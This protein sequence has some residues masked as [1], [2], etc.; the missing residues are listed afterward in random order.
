MIPAAPNATTSTTATT[1]RTTGLPSSPGGPLP[2]PQL[3]RFAGF[4]PIFVRQVAAAALR[5]EPAVDDDRVG[6]HDQRCEDVVARL[7]VERPGAHED[8]VLC[9]PRA[10]DA[11]APIDR[12]LG[13]RA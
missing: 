9:V 7:V 2:L 5:R 3:R 10:V 4:R 6:S 8:R 11:H 13:T 1:R 12:V